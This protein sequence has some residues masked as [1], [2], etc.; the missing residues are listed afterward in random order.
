MGKLARSNIV[1]AV[2]TAMLL[3]G[4]TRNPNVRKQMYVDSGNR[5]FQKQQY[6]SVSSSQNGIPID[7][8]YADAH[9]QLAKSYL[10]LGYWSDAYPGIRPNR[11]FDPRKSPSTDRF[12]E[13]AIGSAAVSGGAAPS[14]NDTQK[15]PNNVDAHILR[16]NAS[17]QLQDMEASLK[18][19]QVASS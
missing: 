16:A 15:D 14:G 6:R 17:A 10:N 4:C 7:P 8:A 11:R 2:L 19:M 18:E 12:R 13:H 5:Y 3:A 9:Y 1:I